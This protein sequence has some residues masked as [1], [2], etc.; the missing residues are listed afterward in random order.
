M[1]YH[2]SR[3]RCEY[4]LFKA[5]PC[6]PKTLSCFFLTPIKPNKGVSLW[7][8]TLRY[9]TTIAL[10]LPSSNAIQAFKSSLRFPITEYCSW[11]LLPFFLFISLQ[12]SGTLS[13]EFIPG[14]FRCDLWEPALLIPII[15]LT[16]IFKI[17]CGY[18]LE[19]LA[20]TQLFPSQR[21]WFF[22]SFKCL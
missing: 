13:W 5:R 17:H 14:T 22:F 8:T 9:V 4:N 20:G 21:Q 12:T 1:K 18:L 15:S 3:K 19:S 11:E 2:L 10:Y 16:N 7:N 6:A